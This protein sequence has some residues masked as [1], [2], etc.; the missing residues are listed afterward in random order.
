MVLW[1]FTEVAMHTALSFEMS[2]RL[3]QTTRCHIPEDDIP[4]IHLRVD[5]RSDFYYDLR[6]SIYFAFDIHILSCVAKEHIFKAYMVATK[7][8]FCFANRLFKRYSHTSAYT[9]YRNIYCCPDA[10]CSGQYVDEWMCGWCCTY[11]SVYTVLP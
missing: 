10:L 3:C 2:V 5:H 1:V 6:R 8:K 11:W 9:W 7:K 4:H